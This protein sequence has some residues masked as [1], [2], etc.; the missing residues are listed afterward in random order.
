LT[1]EIIAAEGVQACQRVW[2]ELDTRGHE[3]KMVV[4]PETTVF[5]KTTAAFV[6]A[7]QI[8]GSG[9]LNE[10]RRWT[11]FYHEVPVG[12]QF[13][14]LAFLGLCNDTSN[15]IRIGPHVYTDFAGAQHYAH[16]VNSG[17]VG[18]QPFVVLRIKTIY[19]EDFFNFTMSALT[20][21]DLHMADVMGRNVVD[22]A[23]DMPNSP[24]ASISPGTMA[25]GLFNQIM[26][27]VS[28]ISWIGFSSI[29]C[30]DCSVLAGVLACPDSTVIN[31]VYLTALNETIASLTPIKN[32]K[33]GWN[34]VTYPQMVTVGGFVTANIFENSG[35]GN[36]DDLS[37]QVL[38]Y[39][40]S[41]DTLLSSYTFGGDSIGLPDYI[42]FSDTTLSWVLGEAIPL[43][44]VAVSNVFNTLQGNLAISSPEANLHTLRTVIYYTRICEKEE[45]DENEYSNFQTAVINGISNRVPFDPNM[46]SVDLSGILP[47]TFAKRPVYQSIYSETSSVSYSSLPIGDGVLLTDVVSMGGAE[48]AHPVAGGDY[49]TNIV[50]ENSICQHQGGGFDFLKNLVP[51]ATD[52]ISSFFPI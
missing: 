43:A 21:G 8:G 50:N 27:R 15:N 37:T 49:E 12:G 18:L 1:D 32:K 45:D 4:Q 16:R 9:D 47:V 17:D 22:Q 42:N 19:I 25:F 24:F 2:T 35:S 33:N 7:R 11:V 3:G 5:D 30:D 41:F 40:P 44:I 46:V 10:L 34:F 20:A 23:V 36:P 31:S 39:F 6:L 38:S 48:F 52:L 51:I 29:P 13:R 14:W 26:R 28:A